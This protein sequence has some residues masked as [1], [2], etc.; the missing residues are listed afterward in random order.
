MSGAGVGT[1]K[2]AI[3]ICDLS[4]LARELWKRECGSILGFN[5]RVALERGHYIF[6]NGKPFC[7][8]DQQNIFSYTGKITLTNL[9]SF[10][11]NGAPC[12]PTDLTLEGDY[13]FN[14]STSY[15]LQSADG[16]L[17]F[18]FLGDGKWSLK[19][20]SSNV[21]DKNYPYTWIPTPKLAKDLGVRIN[22]PYKK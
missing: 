9:G 16:S 10:R 8:Q 17:S 22:F 4:D 13:N 5:A 19:E 15:H 21:E 6:R 12:T 11:L 2:E 20:R 1:G 18:G 14:I 3:E 7:Q